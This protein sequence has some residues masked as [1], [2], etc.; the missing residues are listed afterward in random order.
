ME[1]TIIALTP[2]VSAISGMIG[3]PALIGIVAEQGAGDALGGGGRAGEGD[4]GD[5]DILHQRLAHFRAADGEHQSIL[6]DAGGMGEA[7]RISGDL[8]RLRGRLGDDAIAGGERRR[9]LA[10]EDGER[11]IPGRDADPGAA[12]LHA[13]HVALAGRAGQLPRL[14]MGARLGGVITAEIDGLAHLGE[15]IGNR[16]LRLLDR[17]PHQHV[18]IALE[19][20]GERLEA[21]RTLLD[22]IF[23][24]V[25]EPAHGARDQ[26]S[27][28]RARLGREGQR[29]RHRLQRRA[30]APAGR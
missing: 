23:R 27:R 9:D 19:Q 21:G 6:G 14:E 4:A 8:G 16:L 17:D 26:L 3:R 10:E 22:A 18:A 30:P 7:D 28:R 2:P 15:R 25:F 5:A 29:R 11:E 20:I 24:P 12:A 13:K 1:S